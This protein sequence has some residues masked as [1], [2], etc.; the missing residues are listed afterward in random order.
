MKRKQ[1]KLEYYLVDGYAGWFIVRTHDP[2]I[3]KS[4]GVKEWGR[5]HVKDVS[6]AAKSDIKAYRAI[7]G[8]IE[9]IK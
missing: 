5:G 3:A 9:T 6:I 1:P 8:E 7:K 2:K 4:E